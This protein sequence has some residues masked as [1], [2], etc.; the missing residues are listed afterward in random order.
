M[1]HWD[2]TGASNNPTEEFQIDV[3]QTKWKRLGIQGIRYASN[4][5]TKLSFSHRTRTFKYWL[6][7]FNWLQVIALD[8]PLYNFA[9]FNPKFN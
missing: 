5:Y 1:S 8:L 7:W 2:I 3:F 9:K 4:L 6:E